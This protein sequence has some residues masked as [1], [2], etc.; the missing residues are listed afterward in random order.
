MTKL[1]LELSQYYQE[2]E[3]WPMIR[4]PLVYA[5][6]FFDTPEE[7]ARLNRMLE[8]K[9][10]AVKEA[11]EKHHFNVYIFLHERPWRIHAFKAVQENMSDAKYWSILSDV[12]R[13]SENIFHNHMDWWE[14]LTSD[15][16]RR[17]FFTE[18]E[19][20]KTF[21]KLPAEIEIYRGTTAEEM[22]SNYLGFSWTLD[23]GRAAWFATR[24]GRSGP[25][26]AT[27]VVNKSDCVGYIGSRKE[28]E[29]VIVHQR[30]SLVW[31][32]L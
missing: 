29:V 32:E 26:L 28:D 25:M 22:D 4:H 24:F 27:A 9:K 10:K 23:K 6:P 2:A 21:S 11:E 1:K 19:D 12:W 16:H 7:A 8:Q 15:R 14:L 13:D 5:V 18:P 20:F 17:H 30:N 31:E 3:Q